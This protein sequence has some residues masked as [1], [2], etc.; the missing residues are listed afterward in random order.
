MLARQISK[1]FNKFQ[2]RKFPV[3]KNTTPLENDIQVIKD[4]V[5]NIRK[6]NLELKKTNQ[7]L[8]NDMRYLK[9][10]TDE[11]I[12][13]P[14]PKHTLLGNVVFVLIMLIVTHLLFGPPRHI[15]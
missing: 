3:V 9:G 6:E 15:L 2:Y 4:I 7:A 11:L 8:I 10:K 12:G 1:N 5:I 13:P 14:P